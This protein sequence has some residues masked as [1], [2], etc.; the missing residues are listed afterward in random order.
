MSAPVPSSSLDPFTTSEVLPREVPT[1]QIPTDH[2]YV[3][4]ICDSCGHFHRI[5]L[6][7]KDKTCIFCRKR[8]YGQTI[9]RYKQVMTGNR[10]LRF[11]TLTIVN[12]DRL[13]K[14]DIDKIRYYWKRLYSLKAIKSRIKGGLY[15]IEIT[16][17]GKGWHIH[18]HL[19][20]EGDYIPQSY[21]SNQWHRITGDSRIVYISSV[22]NHFNCF[23]YIS[24][25]LLKSPIVG[26]SGQIL[27]MVLSSVRIINSFGSWY[28]IRRQKALFPCPNCGNTGWISE[29]S[30]S[31]DRNFSE[32]MDSADGTDPP[33]NK[34]QPLDM[35][36][37][38]I[39][40]C[41]N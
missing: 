32:W 37:W 13:L 15:V 23:R 5:P 20:V 7:C 4:I 2:R 10:S 39:N 35:Q 33:V 40:E 27:S 36:L 34:E 16:N 19:I 41:R 30:L 9:S 8:L 21:L 12:R 26:D 6:F 14:S 1:N 3:T 38:L 31:I 24:G 11:L 28:R 29:Y 22:K 25:Y 17:K 18:L